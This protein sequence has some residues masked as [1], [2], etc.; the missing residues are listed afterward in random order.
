VPEVQSKS[1]SWISTRKQYDCN[2]CRKRF[3]VKVG[4][5]FQDSKLPLMKWFLAVY[6]MCE[7]KKGGLGASAQADAEDRQ[8]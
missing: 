3:S 8:L 7:S 5:I 1:I 2:S 6:I 4:T